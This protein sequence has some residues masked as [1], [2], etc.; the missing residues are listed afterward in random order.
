M[1]AILRH[2]APILQR[3]GNLMIRL[4]TI[5]DL[6][7]LLSLETRCF[8]ISD[9]FS[10]QALS[11]L[12]TRAHALTL[13]ALHQDKP[14]GYCNVLLRRN[15]PMARLYS[16]AVLPAMQRQGI[17]Q[18]LLQA[19]EAAVFARGKSLMSLEVRTDNPPAI[20]FYKKYGYYLSGRYPHYYADN[21]DALRFKKHLAL[22]KQHGD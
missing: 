11:Y 21:V 13:L 16:I 3:V 17:A 9:R 10:P 4:A 5:Q 12:L 14:C 19:A 6:T 7:A 18:Q 20:N 22:E 2:H 8:I 15:S 1:A